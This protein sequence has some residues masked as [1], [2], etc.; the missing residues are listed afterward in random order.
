MAVD[1]K[2]IGLVNTKDMFARAIKGGWAVP[3]FNFNNL[4][5]LQAIIQASSNL[6]SPVILQV[7]KGAR[8]YANPTLL[9]YMAEGAVEYAKEL[10]CNHPEIVLHLDHG[11]SFETCKD[12]VD[13][14]FSSVMIDGS[15]LPYEENIALTKKVVDYAHQFGVTVE[16]ELGVLAVCT[17]LCK[18]I[19]KFLRTIHGYF[20]AFFFGIPKFFNIFCTLAVSISLISCFAFTTL[21]FSF[22]SVSFFFKSSTSAL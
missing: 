19:F 18:A 7:S 2:K 15:A 14:G 20:V 12:C 21:K 13:F 6:K 5:Q 9:R 1:Y 16:G 11:D 8:K 4:E 22:I 10:G 3:A 17:H